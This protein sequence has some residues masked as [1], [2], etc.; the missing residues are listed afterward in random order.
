M[1]KNVSEVYF[2]ILIHLFFVS[3]I[4]N[5]YIVFYSIYSLID[6]VIFHNTQGSILNMKKK[7]LNL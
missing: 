3:F 6:I 4:I 1:V 2:V 5:L 7:T